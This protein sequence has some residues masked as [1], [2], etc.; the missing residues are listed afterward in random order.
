MKIRFLVLG[1]FVA[2]RFAFAD[3]PQKC[4]GLPKSQQNLFALFNKFASSGLDRD[5]LIYIGALSEF[6]SAVD[7]LPQND[8]NFGNKF[9]A[10]LFESKAASLCSKKTV[11]GKDVW[12]ATIV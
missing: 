2:G 8:P 10:D 6:N 1:L 9:S 11:N 3:E 7:D 12:A 4:S 5:S